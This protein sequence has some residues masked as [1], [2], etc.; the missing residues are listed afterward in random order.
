M[1]SIIKLIQINIYRGKY[2]DSAINFLKSQEPDV[3]TMQEVTSGRV[4]LYRNKKS[5]LFEL[6]KSKLRFNGVLHTDIRYRDLPEA[7]FGNAVFSKLPVIGY[8]VVRLKRFRPCNFDE[9][10]DPK[11]YFRIRPLLARHLLDATI[12][13][14]SQKVHIISWHGAWTAPPADTKETLRQAKIVANYLKSLN[15]PF[16]LGCDLNNIPESKTVAL[17]S[18]VAK[19]L[20]T[21]ANVNQTTH[22]KVHKIV[23]RGYLIDYIFTSKH[24]RTI[25]LAVPQVT[26]SDHLPV[27]AE[28]ELYN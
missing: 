18:K 7:T 11:S 17:I 3:M 5:D 4:N 26:I 28:L 19:N 10:E 13:I 21:G 20:M 1:S 12:Q 14:Y 23:P 27:I 8:R 2:L 25:S 24:F 9:V 16:I 15:E 22:P 6:L